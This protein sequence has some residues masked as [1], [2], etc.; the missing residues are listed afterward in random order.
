MSDQVNE[1]ITKVLRDRLGAEIVESVDPQ[2]PD[3]PA[4]ANMTYTFQ[5]AIAE[6]LPFHMP[7]YLQ[8]KA[9]DGTLLYAVPGFDVASRDYM[10]RVGEGL[11]P[12]SPKINLRSIND[13]PSSASFGFD[14]ARYLLRRGDTRVTDWASLNANA[15][16]HSQTRVAAMK[17]WENKTNLASKGM[18]QSVQMRDVM[19]MVVQKVMAQNRLDVLVNPTTTLPPAKIG[20]ANQPVVNNRPVGRF[21]TSANLGIPEITVP[22][23]FNRVV[24]EPRFALNAAKNAYETV[25]NETDRTLAAS[26]LPVGISFWAGA[27]E[28][29]AIF[30]VAA[31]YEAATRHRAAP[32]AF[33]PVRRAAPPTQAKPR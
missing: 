21:P 16:Y 26:P 13:G 12:L 8:A 9:A 15:T 22:A 24:Y 19:R 18:T 28:E 2:Y 6:I 23:G 31:A 17:N 25:A 33:G 10:V 14:L 7:E 5:Q 3:D 20:F 32:A 1:E 11:A 30:K 4:I 29:P 27:G